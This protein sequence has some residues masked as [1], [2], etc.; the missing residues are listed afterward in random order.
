M[1]RSRR[2]DYPLHEFGGIYSPDVCVFRSSESTGYAF[3]PAPELLSFMNVAAYSHPQLET[4][5]TGALRLSG[6]LI[7]GTKRKMRVRKAFTV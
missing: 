7:N 2:W 1:D 3:L 6:R 5:A 4:S